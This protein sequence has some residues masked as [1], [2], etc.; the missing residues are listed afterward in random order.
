[1]MEENADS[2]SCWLIEQ[3]NDAMERGAS[4]LLHIYIYSFIFVLLFIDF[5]Y[6]LLSFSWL[7]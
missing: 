6:V 7:S 1:M 2:E 3:I 5:L 4:K